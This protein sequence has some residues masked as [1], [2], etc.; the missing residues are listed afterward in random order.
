MSDT[1][2]WPAV[3]STPAETTPMHQVDALC[4]RCGI[5]LKAIPDRPVLRKSKWYHPVCA[6]VLAR[7][8]EKIR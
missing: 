8:E 1:S 3:P 5:K 6:D 7:T 2:R 4:E